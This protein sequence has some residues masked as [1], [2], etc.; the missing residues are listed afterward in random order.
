MPRRSIA[1][2]ATIGV[3]IFSLALCLD[4]TRQVDKVTAIKYL[5]SISLLTVSIFYLFKGIPK[6]LSRNIFFVSF[7]VL[8]VLMFLGSI[9]ALSKGASVEQTYFGRALNLTAFLSGA[10]F[11]SRPNRIPL[12]T[13][14]LSTAFVLLSAIGFALLTLRSLGIAFQSFPHILH[15]ETTFFVASISWLLWRSERYF[16]GIFFIAFLLFLYFF[17]KKSTTLVLIGVAAATLYGPLIK[18]FFS[19]TNS[20]VREASFGLRLLASSVFISFLGYY[21]YAVIFERVTRNTYDLRAEMWR[22]EWNNFLENPFFGKSF[23]DNPLYF[24]EGR[25][26]DIFVSTHNDYLDILASGGLLGAFF[27]LMPFFYIIFSKR[28][29]LN[30]LSSKKLRTSQHLFI[31]VFV[32]FA[33]SSSGNPFISIPRLAVIV[34]FSIGAAFSITSSQK[35]QSRIIRLRTQCK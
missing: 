28:N 20:T 19:S 14:P 27:Y 31:F 5:P 10:L 11:A 22:L 26:S 21:L 16:V 33:A 12:I 9:V 13:K 1:D 8:I 7:L 3:L 30:I 32:F 25:F 29:F 6:H 17:D 2:L 34:M 4:P 18:K 23:T 35:N 15:V 24:L